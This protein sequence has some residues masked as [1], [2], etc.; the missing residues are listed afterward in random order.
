ML[1]IRS[2]LL[3]AHQ[4]I[5]AK[6]RQ[7]RSRLSVPPNSVVKMVESASRMWPAREAPG[8][9]Q[10]S[11]LNAR[12]P[13]A[14]NGCGRSTSIGWRASTLTESPAPVGQRVVRQVRVEVEGGD[15]IEQA[16]PV[17]VADRRRAARSGSSRA[18]DQR[19]TQPELVD[20]RHAEPLHQ[21]AR[22]LAEALLARH[23]RVAVV[24][25]LHLPL[26]KSSM[27]PTS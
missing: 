14:M 10:S 19:R 7:K 25:V 4:D 8:G 21:R 22:V 13:A 23:Q 15:A 12:F 27:K 2:L 26:P 18:G 11:E 9:S 24:G 3:R 6:L 20:H 1:F 17:E 16:E 5:D